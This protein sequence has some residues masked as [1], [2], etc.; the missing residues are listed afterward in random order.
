MTDNSNGPVLTIERIGA[1]IAVAT[2]LSLALSFV[3]DWGFLSALGMG[4]RDAPTSL[5]DHI[6]SW[7]VWLQMLLPAGFVMF[8]FTLVVKRLGYRKDGSV[9]GRGRGW[10]YRAPLLIAVV[11]LP[12]LLWLLFGSDFPW[13]TLSVLWLL[14]LLWAFSRPITILDLRQSAM[15]IVMS[16]AWMVGWLFS[17]VFYLGNYIPGLTNTMDHVTFQVR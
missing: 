12:I 17:Y 15:G 1:I 6:S 10:T 14:F 8:S 9:G 11:V 2:S 5:S 3:Y 16:I 4:F 7:M 13:W